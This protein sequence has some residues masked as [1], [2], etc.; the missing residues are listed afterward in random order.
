MNEKDIREYIDRLCENAGEDQSFAEDFY[1]RLTADQEILQEFVS[2]MESGNFACRAKVCDYTVVDVM[3]WQI[4]HFK[5]W[6]DR[7][8]TGTKQNKDKMLLNAF[9]ILLKMKQNPESYIQKMQLETGTDYEGKY[10]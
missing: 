8:T 7:D 6:L 1:E 4:D 5:A 10:E 9:D 2:Y 3:V